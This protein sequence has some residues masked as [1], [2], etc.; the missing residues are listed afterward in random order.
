MW[1]KTSGSETAQ[2]SVRSLG[3]VGRQGYMAGTTTLPSH[4]DTH[5]LAGLP[6]QQVPFL[7]T[8]TLVAP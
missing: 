7:A 4:F 1:L 2:A 6:H 3:F 5:Q 8:F